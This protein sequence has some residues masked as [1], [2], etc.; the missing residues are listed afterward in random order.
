M[1]FSCSLSLSPPLFF[2]F[3]P[4]D[5]SFLI[6]FNPIYILFA[7]IHLFSLSYILIIYVLYT[8]V[9][10]THSKEKDST[11]ERS[12]LFTISRSGQYEVSLFRFKSLFRNNCP[13]NSR[14]L[15]SSL[16]SSGF[17]FFFFSVECINQTIGSP[18]QQRQHVCIQYLKSQDI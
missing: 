1:I 14:T 15:F 2:F 11:I 17:F 12:G 3:I 6:I 7:F 16:Y 13:D 18:R 5:G 9:F 8:Y 10:N 4:S